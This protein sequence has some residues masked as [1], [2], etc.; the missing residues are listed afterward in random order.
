[1]DSQHSRPAEPYR[2]PNLNQH[3]VGV[4]ADEPGV[5]ELRDSLVKALKRCSLSYGQH[6]LLH[7]DGIGVLVSNVLSRLKR[8]SLVLACAVT[9]FAVLAIQGIVTSGAYIPWLIIGFGCAWWLRSRLRKYRLV[10]RAFSSYLA[11]ID[12]TPAMPGSLGEELRAGFKL[13]YDEHQAI[14]SGDAELAASLI[15]ERC[16]ANTR[17]AVLNGARF[18][19]PGFG[20]FVGS[21]FSEL[22]VSWGLV[23]GLIPGSIFALGISAIVFFDRATIAKVQCLLQRDDF[24]TFEVG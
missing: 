6:Q 1:M 11:A 19:I 8:F 10:D 5:P 22:P 9:I 13:Q 16:K 20:L 4:L 7:G 23:M 18:C 3:G 17:H 14:R 2:Y 15:I 24:Q 21:L 12:G